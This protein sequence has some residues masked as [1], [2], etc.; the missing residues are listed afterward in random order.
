MPRRN[1][2]VAHKYSNKS[3]WHKTLKKLRAD[4]IVKPNQSETTKATK[5]NRE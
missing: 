2:C 5:K 3:N 1:K 4:L